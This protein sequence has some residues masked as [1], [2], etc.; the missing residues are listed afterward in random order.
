MDLSDL[1]SLMA[2]IGPKVVITGGFTLGDMATRYDLKRTSAQRRVDALIAAG[3]VK[4]I[5]VRPGQG[6]E[7][8]YEIASDCPRIDD[9]SR[10]R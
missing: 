2:D 5:G 9:L 10:D 1:D 7:K 6:Q 3:K 4:Q 8:V